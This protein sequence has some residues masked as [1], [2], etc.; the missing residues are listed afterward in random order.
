M[1]IRLASETSL[2]IMDI[3][4]QLED[5]S[6]A[7]VEVQKIGYL[8]PGQRAA[9][10]SSDLLL[11]QYKRLR[12]EK[13]KK[14]SYK[15]MGTVYTIIIFEKSPKEFSKYPEK[16]IHT[17][18]QNSDTG[19]EVELLQKYVFISL[20]IFR[21]LHQN[22][23]IRNKTEAWLTFLCMDSPEEIIELIKKYPEFKPMYEEVYKLCLNI[24]K[25]MGMFSKELAE[26]DKN[27]V[28]YMMDEMQIEIDAQNEV[29]K[30][31]ENIIQ[32]QSGTIEKQFDTIRQQGST[33]E[34]QNNTIEGQ[35][36]TIEEQ[37]NIINEQNKTIEN[38]GEAIKELEELVRSLKN[39]L[40]K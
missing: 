36:N 4:I 11:R 40:K 27:T 32:E 30:E 38:Q 14:F 29:I 31:S 39:Q 3:V 10:Y 20:D 21:K 7:N 35:N 34:N 13:K 2:L 25:V 16:F 37:K 6:I 12:S 1:I 19:L 8:F 26:M 33:I 24:E 28:I 5:N 18:K 22:K 15:Q 17:F 23:G 9:C